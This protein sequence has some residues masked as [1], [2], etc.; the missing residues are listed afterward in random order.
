MESLM[1]TPLNGAP[2][3]CLRQVENPFAL[4]C[5]QNA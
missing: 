5:G 4:K 2:F 1:L 3:L